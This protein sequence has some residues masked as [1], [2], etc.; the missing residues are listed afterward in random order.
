[1]FPQ[2]NKFRVVLVTVPFPIPAFAQ[3]YCTSQNS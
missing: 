2:F 3:P 1:L